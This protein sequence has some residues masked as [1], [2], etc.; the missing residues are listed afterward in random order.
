MMRG[1]TPQGIHFGHGV[2]TISEPMA[3]PIIRQ[4]KRLE[5]NA[6]HEVTI[7]DAPRVRPVRWLKPCAD[8]ISRYWL[9]SQPHL[10]F[11]T[12]GKCKGSWK[13]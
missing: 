3:T 9:P 5:K 7:L 4:L 1:S 13:T 12:L 2:L 6:G 10:V 11:M 8:Q